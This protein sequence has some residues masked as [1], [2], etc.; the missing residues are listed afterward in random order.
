M[1]NKYFI[2]SHCHLFNLD[3]IAIYEFIRRLELSMEMRL[4]ARIGALLPSKLIKKALGK[5]KK[6]VTFFESDRYDNILNTAKE[7]AQLSQIWP[8]SLS[9]FDDREKIMTPLVMDFEMQ[10]SH[11]KLWNQAHNLI[12]KT[13]EAVED[14]QFPSKTKV[15]PFLGV[16]MRRFWGH[17][18]SSIEERVDKF[19]TDIVGEIK[20]PEE[21][22]DFEQLSSGDV[23]GIKFYPPLGFE[24][25]PSDQEVREKYLI[26]YR[27]LAQF[28]DLPFTVHCQEPS[29][30]LTE[31]HERLTN[32][33]NWEEILQEEGCKDIRINFAHFGGDEELIDTI[34]WS[35]RERDGR[36]FSGINKKTWTYTIIRM[37]K[38][39]Q[40]TY[41]DISA[42]DWKNRLTG[43]TLKLLVEADNNNGFEELP[44]NHKLENKLIWG[45][46]YPMI[47]DNFGTYQEIFEE[48][49]KSLKTNKS[50]GK[51]Y[52]QSGQFMEKLNIDTFIEKIVNENPQKFLFKK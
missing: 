49:L 15:L 46:D 8:D 2:D 36:V 25:L 18:T 31:D 22:K 38:T 16:D 47:L 43:I 34:R 42:L 13:K 19:I 52:Y 41:A 28:H 3:D 10:Q 32:P 1:P 35:N 4:G 11:E 23:I 7:M 17:A 27:R 12:K 30:S 37:L 24:P 50:G 48:F 20:S 51:K 40:N 9:S 5:F 45:S 44:D 26:A 33:S 29:Y 6:F 14:N 21:R 39:Y